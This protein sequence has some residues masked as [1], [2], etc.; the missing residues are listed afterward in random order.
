MLQFKLLKSTRRVSASY[1]EATNG[2]FLLLTL[3]M[4][5]N[6]TNSPMALIEAYVIKPFKAGAANGTDTVV[7]NQEMLLPPHK[8]VVTLC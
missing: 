1:V 5:I 6:S 4:E 7:W 2:A 8:Y 3:S